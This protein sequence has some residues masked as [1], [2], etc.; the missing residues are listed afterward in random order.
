[1]G[2]RA[3]LLTQEASAHS[4]ATTA[5]ISLSLDCTEYIILLTKP[6]IRQILW[7]GVQ[8]SFKESIAEGIS[9]AEIQ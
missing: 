6:E 1:M 3:A 8:N 4:E 2:T 5:G 9:I 7:E